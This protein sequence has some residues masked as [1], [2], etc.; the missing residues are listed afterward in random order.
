MVRIHFPPSGESDANL[1]SGANP[2]DGRRGGC[3]IW[4]LPETPEEAILASQRP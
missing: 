3:V 1:F 2:I 4:P